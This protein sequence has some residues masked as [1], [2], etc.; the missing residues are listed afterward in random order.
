L[1]KDSGVQSA[2]N[3]A[4]GEIESRISLMCDDR[5]VKRSSF[6]YQELEMERRTQKFE[7]VYP[8]M[9]GPWIP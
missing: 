6:L 1:R 7:S 9:Y 4:I 5:G 2:R 8:Q 3:F